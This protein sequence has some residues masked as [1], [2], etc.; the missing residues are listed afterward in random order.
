MRTFSCREL[1]AAQVNIPWPI[2]PLKK[3]TSEVQVLIEEELPEDSS[4]EEYNPEQD[5]QSDDEREA[6][7]LT[8]N[9]IDYQPI[10]SANN[11][12]SSSVEQA[13]LLA[14]QYDSEGIFKIPG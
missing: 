7:N 13:K 5:K 8:S 12:N 10:T 14:V 2:T 9:N 3:T 6:K 4:D 11:Y 1:A